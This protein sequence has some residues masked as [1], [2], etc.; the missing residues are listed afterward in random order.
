[1]LHD[2]NIFLQNVMYNNIS[3][4]F[5]ISEM[6]S[7]REICVINGPTSYPKSTL[8]KKIIEFGG[9]IVQNPGMS[10]YLKKSSQ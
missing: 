8:E 5:Q 3:K 2:A 6:L 4:M 10:Y 7:G 9:T 1:M